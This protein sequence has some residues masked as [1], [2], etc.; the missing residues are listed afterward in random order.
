MVVHI[1]CHRNVSLIGTRPQSRE[2]DSHMMVL[3]AWKW[4]PRVGSAAE[5]K[6]GD[7]R[8]KPKVL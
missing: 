7:E 6:H 4:K 2:Q 5:V 3:S 1:G 8:A